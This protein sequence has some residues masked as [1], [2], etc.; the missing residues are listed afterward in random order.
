[1]K[2]EVDVLVI[3]AGSVGINSAFHLHG[4]GRHVEVVDKGEV[5][6]GSSHGNAGWIVP[7]HSIPLAAPGVMWRGVRWMFNPESPFY[8]K[9]R[10]D[11]ELLSWLWDFHRACNQRHVDRSIPLIRDL[12]LAS[13]ELFEELDGL[14]G[15]EFDFCQRGMLML[16]PDQ[17]S[18]KEAIEE[19]HHLRENG[20]EADILNPQQIRELEPNVR[21]NAVGGV[22][23]SQDA[24]LT[25]GHFVRRLARYIEQRGVKIHPSTEVLGFEKKYGRIAT[26]RTTRGE[27]APAEVVLAGGAWSSGLVEDLKLKLPIQAAKGYSITYEK[28]QNGPDVPLMLAGARV[29]VTPMGDKLRFAGTLELAGL[30]FSINRRRVQAILRAVPQYL[31]DLDLERLKLV[32]IWR[33]LRPCTPDGLPFLGRARAFENLVVAA[34]HAMIGLSLGPITGKLVSQLVAGEQTEMDLSALAVERFAR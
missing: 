10:L 7:S 31:P 9:P 23:F 6:A 15:L 2:R 13:L 4:Q 30:D 22:H 20:L 25:P 26:V 11:R 12:S 19:A 21:I 14:E 27:F 5:C 29:G 33:G 28:P 16:C 8:I 24:H 32:E 3:G 34:G 18:L 1:M 17:D